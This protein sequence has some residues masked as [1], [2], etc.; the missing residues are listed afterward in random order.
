MFSRKLPDQ[1]P[2]PKIVVCGV[3]NPAFTIRESVKKLL[4]SSAI[5]LV[6]KSVFTDLRYGHGQNYIIFWCG[7]RTGPITPR[8]EPNWMTDMVTW[9]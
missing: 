3:Y 2:W 1:S 5:P 6:C 8:Q 9:V 4:C 7:S